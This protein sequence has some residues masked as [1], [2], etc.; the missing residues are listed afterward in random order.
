ML[1][2]CFPLGLCL[3]AALALFSLFAPAHASKHTAAPS[4]LSVDDD[5]VPPVL[6]GEHSI[7]YPPGAPTITEPVT[8]R[9][10]LRVDKDGR[11]AE[12]TLVS[13]G[14]GVFDAAVLSAVR[15]F[16]FLPAR[17]KGEPVRVDIEFTQKYVPQDP[18]T[19]TSTQDIPKA[20]IEGFVMER[21]T[22]L[23]L[24]GATVVASRG[25][26]KWVATTAADGWFQ[27]DVAP[28]G[29]L[30]VRIVAIGCEPFRQKE[31]L[32]PSTVL[33]VKYLVLRERYDPY[34]TVIIGEVDRV[35]V[36]RTSLSAGEI[37][38]VPGTFGDPF[39]VADTLPSVNL[40]SPVMP[41][42][43]TRGTSPASTGVLL[44]GEELPMLFHFLSG[45][46]VVHPEFIESVDVYPG[47][48]PVQFGRYTGG[49]IN[50]RVARF[51][52]RKPR[53]ELDLNLLQTG[54]F[55]RKNIDTMNLTTTVAGRIGYPGVVM[56]LLTDEVK[57]QYWDYQ[58]RVDGG[59]RHRGWSVMILGAQD[60]V[61]LRG[62]EGKMRR[63]LLLGFHRGQAFLWHDSGTFR[64]TYHVVMSRE[65]GELAS[66]F[67]LK[68]W[69]IA[70]KARWLWRLSE[71]T[72][73]FFGIDTRVRRA[74]EIKGD[75]DSYAYSELAEHFGVAGDG[76]VARQTSEASA[77]LEARLRPV[78]DWLVVPGIRADYYRPGAGELR[79]V[80]PR[81]STRYR[82]G[83][84]H[85]L[86]AAVGWFHQPARATIAL[87]GGTI[88]A[89]DS[90]LSSTIQSSAG[91]ELVLS[92][93]YELEL[94]AFHFFMDQ[95]YAEPYFNEDF[96]QI[97]PGDELPLAPEY[98][99]YDAELVRPP[100]P[101]KKR[102]RSYGVEL[103]VRKRD[104][105]EFFGWVAYSLWK[106]E[107]RMPDG[108][109]PYDFDIRHTVNMV[110]GIRL[111][112]NWEISTRLVV[113]SG[114]P[115]TTIYGYNEG[116]SL[117][118]TRIDLRIDK[119]AVF[120]NYLFDFYFDLV[121]AAFHRQTMIPGATG[122]VNSEFPVLPTFGVRAVLGS[123]GP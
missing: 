63:S 15:K 47:N 23:P 108:W 1:H 38:R 52:E 55:A 98:G 118:E 29:T 121:N 80:D 115:Q 4:L 32:Q 39:R 43:I 42:I 89:S 51:T 41:M 5:L 122:S 31:T 9:I 76:K 25:E 35:A 12:V 50:G 93:D 27:L 92:H 104:R 117:T 75:T 116:R 103:M 82:I 84:G 68:S 109:A 74:R 40:A 37:H 120:D 16:R 88:Q 72:D 59:T 119:R 87:A 22:H 2:N 21:G 36:S 97:Q 112:R 65:R 48:F 30:D 66:D 14:G 11:V 86:K 78:G 45:P 34:E 94:E 67:R 26:R 69:S 46:S 107:R 54:L 62:M 99:Y 17:H 13:S 20:A 3:V 28:G 90:I 123:A 10:R 8:V 33:R 91:L 57:L 79:S 114:L 61:D 101:R 73:L 77:F 44:D 113:R 85:W 7:P 81:L 6:L 106:S 111:P 56:R 60:A 100:T 71:K 70:P 24:S 83:D 95:I 18:K 53:Y 58:T 64:G 49:V 105:G 110:L 102:G 19:A 96:N